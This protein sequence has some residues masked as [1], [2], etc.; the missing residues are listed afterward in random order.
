MAAPGTLN[1]GDRVVFARIDLAGSAH[2]QFGTVV[3]SRGKAA[4][5]QNAATEEGFQT[6]DPM[7]RPAEPPRRSGKSCEKPPHRCR[8]GGRAG[9]FYLRT[10]ETLLP[11]SDAFVYFCEEHHKPNKANT[12]DHKTCDG[13][14]KTQGS[15]LR[16]A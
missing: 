4:K 1:A 6:G 13:Q 5:L 12:N 15:S 14:I 8:E 16:L 2:H 10:G 7:V 9:T 11:R 3:K